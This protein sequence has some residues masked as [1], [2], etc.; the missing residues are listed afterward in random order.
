[1]EHNNLDTYFPIAICEERCPFSR[2]NMINEL[3]FKSSGWT[4]EPK[5]S[6]LKCVVCNIYKHMKGCSADNITITVKKIRYHFELI[7]PWV[8]KYN[9]VV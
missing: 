6:V 1:M 7:K 5:Y 4:Q 9:P 3:F 8:L 2:K